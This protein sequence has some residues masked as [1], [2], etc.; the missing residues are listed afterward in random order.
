M[1]P[2]LSV[3]NTGPGTSLFLAYVTRLPHFGI[4]NTFSYQPV[5]HINL[6][7]SIIS[8]VVKRELNIRILVTHKFQLQK[9]R[10]K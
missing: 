7:T 2:Y 1:G 9:S 8:T 6:S 10:L 3:Q 5:S 4:T